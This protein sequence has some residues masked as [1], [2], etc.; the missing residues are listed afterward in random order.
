MQQ[1]EGVT[2]LWEAS[3]EFVLLVRAMSCYTSTAW[4]EGFFL[5]TF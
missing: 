2:Y 5:G 1:G 3:L 4:N